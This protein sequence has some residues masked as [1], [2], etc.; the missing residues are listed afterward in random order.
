MKTTPFKMLLALSVAGAV[1][2]CGEK[3][4]PAPAVRAAAP[5]VQT[6]PP[7][8]ADP[9]DAKVLKR[10]LPSESVKAMAPPDPAK[11]ALGRAMF[12]DSRLSRSGQTACSSCHVLKSSKSDGAKPSIA[13]DGKRCIR[14]DCEASAPSTPDQRAAVAAV[15]RIPRY[16]ELFAAAFP[17][18]QRPMNLK[19][20]EDA[21]TSFERGLATESRWDRYIHGDAG[22][23]SAAEKTGLK[24]FLDAGCQSCHSGPDLG[25]TIFQKLGAVIPWPHQTGAKGGKSATDRPIKVPSLKVA[26]VYARY[27]R[28]SS[29][30]K[31]RDSIQKMAYHQLGI[32]L[33]SDDIDVIAVW[34]D[35]LVGDLDPAYVAAP[36]PP[37]GTKVANLH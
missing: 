9:I 36:A 37:D 19:N 21:L 15:Q 3:R 20:I 24:A 17:G 31:L 11:V 28:D 1:A 10:F 23:L 32:Q 16:A 2:S 13:T 18:E 4:E 7:A 33:S 27:F 34:M 5:P 26:T 30:T 8:P 14:G 22:A 6:A 12:Y 25:G 29:S 35:T